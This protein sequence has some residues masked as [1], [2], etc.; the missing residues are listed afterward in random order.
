MCCCLC[1]KEKEFSA[2]KPDFIKRF[3]QWIPNRSKNVDSWNLD[4]DPIPLLI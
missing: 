2:A 1:W 4:K 3:T